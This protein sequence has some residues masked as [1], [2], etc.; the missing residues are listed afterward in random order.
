MAKAKVNQ[1]MGPVVELPECPICLDTMSAPIFQ[2]QSGHSLC[3]SC[4][5]ALM[6]PIC[7]LCRQAMTQVRNWQ[8]EDLL[9]K[10]TMNCPNRI[11][12]CAYTTVASNMENHI[13]ECIYREMICPL[14]V[15]GR[16]SWSGKLKEMLD[17]F[18]EHHSQNLIM[19]MD[20]KV[21]INNLN[22]NED[23][24]FVYIMPQGKMM[25]IVTL[26][27]DTKLKLAFF[28]VQLIACQKIAQQHVYEL[29]ITSLQDKER[30]VNYFDHCFS[31]ATETREILQSAKCCVMSLSMLGNFIN[32]KSLSFSLNVQRLR[33]NYQREPNKNIHQVNPNVA[34]NRQNFRGKSPSA[35][36]HGPNRPKGPWKKPI[37]Q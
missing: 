15:F 26:K 33:P 19:T 14:H 1:K 3:S 12:G 32:K 4:T 6:P 16:C 30:R 8:L 27:I 11:I 24:R 9:L 36:T 7:P 31:D 22:I 23:D 17:H 25:F 20:Q 34:K 5:K 29:S 18:K 2:C 21:T 28:A 13:K 37:N 10:A 35:V